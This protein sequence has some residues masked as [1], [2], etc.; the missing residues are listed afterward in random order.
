[1]A[2]LKERAKEKSKMW[3]DIQIADLSETQN[4]ND[5]TAGDRL[6]R[7]RTELANERTLLAYTRTALGFIAVGIPAVWWFTELAIQALGVASLSIGGLLIGAGI[8]RFFSVKAEI[9]AHHKKY[10]QR[11][12]DGEVC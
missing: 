5:P 9:D 7:Y 2:R 3:R 12:S 6:A 11:R 8:Y 1:M 4:Q 10:N